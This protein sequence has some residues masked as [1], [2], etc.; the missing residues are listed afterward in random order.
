MIHF[1]FKLIIWIQWSQY[2]HGELCNFM[3]I[4]LQASRRSRSHRKSGTQE[5][6]SKPPGLPFGLQEGQDIT[7]P[8]RALEWKLDLTLDLN[9]T[10]VGQLLL[11]QTFEMWIKAMVQTKIPHIAGYYLRPFKTLNLPLQEDQKH[12]ML[13]FQK[14]G[15]IQTLTLRII[16]R[17]PSPMNPTFTWREVMV[18]GCSQGWS[19]RWCSITRVHWPWLPVL[20]RTLITLARVMPPLSILTCEAHSETVSFVKW[21][22]SDPVHGRAPT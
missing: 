22:P 9:I 18:Y 16:W 3:I 21:T 15:K 14:Y 12:K 19:G 11:C 17:L 20:S 10:K 1:C 4:K 6:L 13:K 8:H 5:S 7:L 2:L